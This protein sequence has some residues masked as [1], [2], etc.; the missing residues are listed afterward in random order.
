[1]T[2]DPW[3]VLGIKPGASEEE[4]KGA[5]KKLAFENHPDLHPGDKEA[6]ARM[7]SINVAFEQLMKKQETPNVGVNPGWDT[8]TYGEYVSINDLINSILNN[9]GTGGPAHNIRTY[10]VV[11]HGNPVAA[12]S[13]T[14]MPKTTVEKPES[15]VVYQYTLSEADAAKGK[16]ITI[17]RRGK[18]LQVTIPQNVKNGQE[19]RL[20]D[21][22]NVT[23]GINGSIFIRIIIKNH[24]GGTNATV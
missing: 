19:I 16:Q 18:K 13:F 17:I 12:A 15:K 7:R 10:K 24:V 23:D 20:K 9:V 6:E 4:I 1:M 8:F 2:T 21:A 11:F 14:G 3:T 5:Y 22:L